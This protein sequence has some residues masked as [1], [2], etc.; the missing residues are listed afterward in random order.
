MYL[1]PSQAPRG[2][3]KHSG[4]GRQRE[5]GVLGLDGRL[6]GKGRN[7]SSSGMMQR[8]VWEWVWVRVWVWMWTWVCVVVGKRSIVQ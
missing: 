3:S 7:T 2:H 4:W 1:Y 5:R 8:G 6:C